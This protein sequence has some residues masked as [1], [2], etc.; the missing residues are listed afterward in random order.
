MWRYYQTGEKSAWLT[1]PDSPNVLAEA[2]ELG[3]KRITILAT[4][5]N[6]NGAGVESEAELQALKDT[7]SYKGPLYFD[8]DNKQDLTQ[9]LQSTR[10]LVTKLIEMGCD[11]RYIRVYASGSKGFHVLVDSRTFCSGRAVKDLPLIYKEMARDL[12]VLGMD[13][14]VYSRGRG[15]IWRIANV[16]RDDGRYRVELTHK[17]LETLDIEGYA[18]LCSAVKDPVEHPKDPPKMA[19]QLSTLFERA[20]AAVASAPKITAPLTDEQIA[21]IREKTPACIEG[22]VEGQTD[23]SVSLNEAALQL[24]IYCARAGISDAVA[25]TLH[26]RMADKWSSSKY[27]TN[28]ARLDHIVGVGNYVAT[29]PSYSFSCKPLIK[30]LTAYPCDGCPLGRGQQEITL[31]N[32]QWAI[33]EGGYFSGPPERRRQLSNFTIEV[34]EIIYES[35]PISGGETRTGM[36]LTLQTQDRGCNHFITET[37]FSSRSSLIKELQGKLDCIWIGNDMDVQELK[38]VL[39]NKENEMG[40]ITQVYTAGLILEQVG[41]GRSQIA[42]YVEEKGSVNHFMVGDTHRLSKRVGAIPSLLEIPDRPMDSEAVDVALSSLLSSNQEA[43]VARIG[44][45]YAACHLKPHIM[46]FFHQFPI[47]SLW[48]AAG[49]GKTMSATLWACLSGLRYHSASGIAAS[50][51]GGMSKFALLDMCTTT[52][53]VPR[54]LDEFNQSKLKQDYAYASEILKAAWNGSNMPRGTLDKTGNMRGR[55]GASTI[56]LPIS[57]PLV[58]MSEQSL[59]EPAQQQRAISVYLT[60]RHREGKSESFWEAEKRSDRLL[61]VAKAM[62]MEALTTSPAQVQQELQTILESLDSRMDDR[63]RFSE[64]VVILGLK[65]LGKVCTRNNLPASK[66][67]IDQLVTGL[68]DTYVSVDGTMHLHSQISEI[69]LVLKAVMSMVDLTEARIEKCIVEGVHYSVMGD[70]FTLAPSFHPAYVRFVSRG[71][72]TPVIDRYDQFETLVEQEPYFI[73][74]SLKDATLKGD[75]IE[76]SVSAMSKKGI[77]VS[78]INS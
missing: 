69:D 48:G 30:M 51:V 77:D 45:W 23:G 38:G 26:S 50:S 2:T 72:R 66:A 53:T 5:N 12:H 55:L 59:P 42:V 65:F 36:N 78:I 10:D 63:R 39:L 61:D 70:A 21:P 19:V 9:A 17:E 25:G 40:K 67:L 31:S 3:A 35:D 46:Q 64:S 16:Q 71:Q 44:G 32:P 37:S 11:P 14:Q 18:T 57:S 43:V 56:E 73:A 4:S 52:T 34:Q 68:Q 27:S 24:G 22:L 1:I 41:M 33:V 47:L 75:C 49:S 28:R 62:V 13:F 60:R 58:F 54:L 6:L 76:L 20:R 7:T 74:K 8:I 29:T 15:C